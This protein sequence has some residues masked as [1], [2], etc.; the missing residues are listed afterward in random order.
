M[1]KKPL[2]EMKQ[3]KPSR[4]WGN[5]FLNAWHPDAKGNNGLSSLSGRSGPASTGEGKNKT[6]S[7]KPR[8]NAFWGVSQLHQDCLMKRIDKI[9]KSR[10]TNWKL[11]SKG[12]NY[13]SFLR[14]FTERSHT[15]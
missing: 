11:V 7:F 1:N 14:H 5:Y 4:V 12:V 3:N 8:Q 13:W 9:G 2:K 6:P 15:E 10:G